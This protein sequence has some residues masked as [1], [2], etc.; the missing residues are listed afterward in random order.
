M[1]KDAHRSEDDAPRAA[2]SATLKVAAI[3]TGGLAI[4]LATAPDALARIAMNHS[5][6]LV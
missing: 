3:L 4:C 6:S 2:A 1:T 5:E